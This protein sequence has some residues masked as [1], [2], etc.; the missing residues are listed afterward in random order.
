MISMSCLCRCTTVH[1]LL[2]K[3]SKNGPPSICHAVHGALS[4][5][6]TTIFRLALLGF[7]LMNS[8]S[9]VVQLSPPGEITASDTCESLT[10]VT[11]NTRFSS[12]KKSGLNAEMFLRNL[13][14]MENSLLKYSGYE[15]GGNL[16]FEHQKTGSDDESVDQFFLFGYAQFWFSF[17]TDSSSSR[18]MVFSNDDE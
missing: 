13:S 6:I 1:I 12:Y 5:I 4:A 17:S 9:V 14:D 11:S 8:N 18:G 15:G 16:Y 2:G 10:T 3:N 7:C